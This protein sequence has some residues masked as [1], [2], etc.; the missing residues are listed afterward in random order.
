[1]SVEQLASVYDFQKDKPL[2]IVPLQG[3]HAERQV[4]V[5]RYLLAA[6]SEVYEQEWVNLRQPLTEHNVHSLQNLSRSLKNE[7]IFG[8]RGTAKATEYKLLDIAKHQTYSMIHE[9]AVGHSQE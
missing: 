5:A 4:L 3:S 2:L 8:I 7:G 6:Y 9:L 1:L